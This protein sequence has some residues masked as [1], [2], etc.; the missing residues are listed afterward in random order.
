M[1]SKLCEK[2][3]N[4]CGALWFSLSLLV[5]AA[6]HESEKLFHFIAG[7]WVVFFILFLMERDAAKYIPVPKEFRE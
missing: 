1:L 5:G 4:V 6:A 2:F 3:P 7:V